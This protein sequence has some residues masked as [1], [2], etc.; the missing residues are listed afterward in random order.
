MFMSLSQKTS[1]IWL[2]LN[3]KK[4]LPRTVSRKLRLVNMSS[5]VSW[6]EMS[7]G[8]VWILQMDK[9][10]LTANAMHHVL[11]QLKKK[12]LKIKTMRELV[13]QRT[14][15]VCIESPSQ[16]NN[17]M[18]ELKS[19]LMI[20]NV[21]LMRHLKVQNIYGIVQCKWDKTLQKVVI[22]LVERVTLIGKLSLQRLEAA[23]A[24]H[25]LANYTTMK[26]M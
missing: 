11:N 26:D 1:H 22:A 4:N 19:L 10:L 6:M 3:H 13:E 5:L 15:S 20:I 17:L 14:K 23:L 24:A 7:A 18:R 8:L 16:I 21:N 9:D 12:R 25:T 2:T